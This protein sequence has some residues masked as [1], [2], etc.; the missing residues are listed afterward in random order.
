MREVY[1]DNFESIMYN[2]SISR[3]IVVLPYNVSV[4]GGD[5]FLVSRVDVLKNKYLQG[6]LEEDRVKRVV[7]DILEKAYFKAGRI[8][9]TCGRD[10]VVIDCS[11]GSF[12][13]TEGW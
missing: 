6:Y 8:K 9:G 11:N 3:S 10:V 1:V 2:I 7:N 5:G 13:N 4:V 12:V